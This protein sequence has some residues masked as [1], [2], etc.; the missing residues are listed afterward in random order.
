MQA[1]GTLQF[2]TGNAS[3]DLVQV[4]MVHGGVH[5]QSSSIARS[6]EYD[7]RAF[8]ANKTIAAVSIWSFKRAKRGRH[9]FAVVLSWFE[10]KNISVFRTQKKNSS[11]PAKSA[12]IPRE[13]TAPGAGWQGQLRRPRR[14][15]LRFEYITRY[16]NL[17]K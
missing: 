15:P 10:N 3:G 1:H 11:V 4:I 6:A 12:A 5:I 8:M 14:H 9:N 17:L 16:T 7:Q 13:W 2:S